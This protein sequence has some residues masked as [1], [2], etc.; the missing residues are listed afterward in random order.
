MRELFPTPLIQVD[1][2]SVEGAEDAGAVLS[3][4]NKKAAGSAA[5]PAELN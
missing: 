3:M 5:I 2:N 4:E 1:D